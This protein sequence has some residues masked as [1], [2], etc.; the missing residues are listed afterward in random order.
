M[1]CSLVI[2]THLGIRKAEEALRTCKLK[3]AAE[4]DIFWSSSNRLAPSRQSIQ[5]EL[6]LL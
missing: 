6:R 5:K 3:V 4:M 2:F 1:L